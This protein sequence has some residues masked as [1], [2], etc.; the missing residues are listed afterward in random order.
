MHSTTEDEFQQFL[1]M[2]SM[3]NMG[4]GINYDFHD[5]HH[6][7]GS[8]LLQSPSREQLDTPMSGT[9]T[10]MILS[11][12]DPALQQHMPTITTSSPYQT[13][14]TTMM[15][16]STPTEAI[17][18]SI[19]AQIQFLQ[20]QKLDHQQRQLD[21]Q[22]AAFFAY[23]QNHMVPPTPQSLE[24]QAAAGQYYIRPNQAEQHDH[25]QHQQTVNYQYP[26]LKDRHDVRVGNKARLVPHC[27]LT[28]PRCRLLHWYHPP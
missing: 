5:F 8:H 9:E 12:V 11:R 27:M 24:L 18:D 7:T 15:G 22:R 14:P 28:E 1:D 13:I 26:R 4:D 2:N 16:T 3:G 20:R 17:V 23:Q 21:E 19:E 25:R 6:S 10:A